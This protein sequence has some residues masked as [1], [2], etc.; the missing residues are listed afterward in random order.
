M[1][2]R[3]GRICEDTVE[4]NYHGL[5]FGLEDGA[6]RLIP[7]LA[8]GDE[9]RIERIR[10]PTYPCRESGG[11]VWIFVP[12]RERGSRTGELPPLPTADAV[13]NLL[14]KGAE[15][16]LFPCHV[17]WAAIGLTDPAHVTYVH[18]S[19]W[20]GRKK[21]LRPKEKD[22]RPFPLGYRMGPHEMAHRPLPYRLLGRRI[23]VEITF[24]LPGIRIEVIRGD[25][26]SAVSVTS[27]TPLTEGTCEVHHAIYTTRPRMWWMA[28]LGGRLIRTFL[29]QDR[30]F[31]RM[32]NEGVAHDDSLTLVGDA[33]QEARWYFALKREY[34]ESREQGR[35]FRNPVEA[36]T[37]RWRS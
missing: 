10:V 7:S 14:P 1:P 22:F 21:E 9:V 5:R 11:M 4:C 6:C 36:R 26:H 13:G 37:L 12:E 32:Q 15:S 27:I 29:G 23:E 19:W 17:D 28:L 34:L 20:W 25:R 2:L 16:L 30:D 3:H 35:E 18:R 33:D 31:A 24:V 8:D